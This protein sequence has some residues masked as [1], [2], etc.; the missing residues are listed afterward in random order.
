MPSIRETIDIRAEPEAVF[1]LI[2]RIEDFPLYADFIREVSVTGDKTSH[3]IARILG[4]SLEW[5]AVVTECHRPTQFAWQS[6]SGAS[7]RGSYTL[8]RI[9]SGTRAFFDHSRSYPAAAK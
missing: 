3:W 1:D 8:E 2:T 4:L 7:S 5:D 9:S 6:V